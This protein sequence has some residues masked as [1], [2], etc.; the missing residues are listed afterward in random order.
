MRNPIRALNIGFPVNLKN[1]G[2]PTF[3]ADSGDIRVSTTTLDV[4]GQAVAQAIVRREELRNR[5]LFIH[6]AVITQNTLL[7]FAREI[8]PDREF[9]IIAVD[10]Q[11][12][13]AEA[14]KKIEAGV[15]GREVTIP[16]LM[17]VSFGLE[18]GLFEAT[19]NALLG[20]PMMGD[21]EVKALVARYLE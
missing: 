21:E 15:T 17:R 6:S 1:D 11:K 13:A 12:A 5:F 19:D 18:L 2:R 14:W 7:E 4:I 8:A 10:T 20:L 3:L 9:K 16:L